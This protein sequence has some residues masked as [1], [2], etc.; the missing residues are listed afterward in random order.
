MEAV[1]MTKVLKFSEYPLHLPKFPKIEK[2]F[3]VLLAEF[4]TAANAQ[5]QRRIMNKIGKFM[6]EVQTDFTIISVRHSIDTRDETYKKANDL[7]N[8]VGP[9]VQGLGNRYSK[10][11]LA[12]KHRVE[13]EKIVGSFL[14]KKLELA[15]KT[16]DQKIL[17]DLQEENR[18]S[19]EYDALMASAQIAFDGGTYNLSQMGKFA[20]SK[21]RDIRKRA[22]KA[23]EQWM[24]EKE[25]PLADI[26]SKLVTLRHG[27]AKKL[28]YGS[29][30]QMA[31]DRMGRTDYGPKDVKSYRDQILES[32]VPLSNK[33]TRQQIKRIDVPAP[34]FYDLAIQFKDGNATPKGDK[35]YLVKAALTMYKDMGKE[36]GE[37]FQAMVDQELLDLEAKPGKRGGGYMTFFPRYQMPFV[38]SNFNGTA[39]D[40]D[41]LT[42]E[43][44][45]AFQGFMSRKIKPVEYRD[46]T[47]EEAE[48]HSMS[49]EFFATPYMESFFK[50][51]K[52]KYLFGH[53]EGAI[54]FLPYGVTVDEFQHWV[55]EN[56]TVTHDQRC[57]K[58]RE[59]EIKYTPYKKYTGFPLYEKGARWMRQAHIY[60]SPFYYIDYTLAQVI[61]LQFLGLMKKNH[62]KAWKKYVKVC[63]LGGKYPFTQLLEKAKLKNPFIDGT[64][65]KTFRP[66][67]KL[68]KTYAEN[69]S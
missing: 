66:V 37:F 31:Y 43:I 58:W 20:V 55:Y 4:E 33:L 44:G 69:L 49:M 12:S 67:K 35:N 15:A 14:F 25:Q 42:H 18:L 60:S 29:F 21:D 52:D 9:M 65:K 13:L 41:V 61:A 62:A 2:K 16:F 54:N 46:P 64:I 32:V 39:G 59:I 10:A 6:D 50:E 28:G 68:L 17:Q 48:I 5:I 7:I 26:Y 1:P 36:I 51:D 27:M 45:H 53:L 47:M 57:A 11:V 22:S 23:V 3:N 19:T 24:E 63:S 56:P 8:E 34:K 30:T 40:V 38:F